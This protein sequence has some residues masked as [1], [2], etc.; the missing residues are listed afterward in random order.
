MFV[1]R[2][3]GR[4]FLPLFLLATTLTCHRR[5]PGG[6]AV[7][8]RRRQEFTTLHER[9]RGVIDAAANANDG[10]GRELTEAELAAVSADRE[11]A[12]ALASE[13]EQLVE[14]E[15]RAA[16]VAAGYAD[17][18][19]P[20]EQQNAGTG[21]T[22]DE[23]QR[24]EHDTSGTSAQDRDPGHYRSATEGGENSFFADIVRA[25][26][27]D[28][29]AATR[30]QEHNRALSTGVGG[31]GIV[32]PRWLIEEYE[33]IARQ[34]RV[35]AEMVRRIEITNPSPMTLQ[36]QTA[37][38]DGV[39]AQQ[40]TENT[41]PS[42]TDAFATTVDVVTPKPV[43]GIQVV[44]RQ[45][46]DMTN[47]AAD[48][49]IFGDMLSVYNRKIEDSVT[50]ALVTAAGTATVALATE[51][52]FTAAAAEDAITDAA[53]AVWNA[54]KLPADVVAMAPTIKEIA[55]KAGPLLVKII[56][57][58]APLFV[59][60]VEAALDLT[61]ALLPV[62][63]PLL[64]M[65]NNA[66]PLV[67]GVIQD[68]LIPVIKWLVE[69]F[70]GLIEYGVKIADKFAEL[71]VRWRT[72]WDEIKAAFADADRRIRAGIDGFVSLGETA[73]KHWDAMYQ[74]IKGK[75]EEIVAWAVAFPQRIIDGI[76]PLYAAGQRIRGSEINALPALYRTTG[77]QQNNTAS[78]V[79]AT[80][81]AFAGEVNAWY[82]IECFLFY[83][84]AMIEAPETVT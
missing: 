69:E 61:K 65:A 73:R 16:R 77:D 40:A 9:S 43:S 59:T 58:L 33:A 62:I 79:N 51:A 66:M 35:V 18:G 32:P 68:V 37:G 12:E 25:R 78:Y 2:R 27:G 57:A 72:Y 34:G 67:K 42:E 29:E 28:G 70:K 26:E 31:A 76:M 60:L 20:A 4:V 52:A 54:R 30:L 17:I 19:A 82:L 41:H 80:G 1:R 8:T 56:D 36:R 45:M 14:D 15:L 48:A 49:L 46:I 5:A 39:L 21:E 64:D 50:A 63:P 6:S 13:I 75:I 23:H 71:S 10:A 53:I 55:E 44:S 81:L 11:R 22:E 38:T 74:A 3:R 83:K 84:A 7:L 24:S 47:P